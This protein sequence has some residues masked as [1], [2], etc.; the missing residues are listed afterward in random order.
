M[1]SLRLVSGLL[2]GLMVLAVAGWAW[3][4]EVRQV[5]AEGVAA[6]QSGAAVARDQAVE[7]ALRR[8]VEQAVGVLVMAET[9]VRNRELLADKIYTQAKGYVQ[10]YK[11]VSER[12]D[13]GLYRVAIL[14]DVSLE[15]LRN[16]L[17]AIRL[18]IQR[19]GKPRVLFLV[20]EE[21]THSYGPGV[22]AYSWSGASVTENVLQRR[23]RDQGFPV[24]EARSAGLD[25]A[26]ARSA[27]N[28]DV[29]A[30]QRVSQM[31]Q[32]EVVV[33]GNARAQGGSPIAGSSLRAVL[34]DMT[35]RAVRADTGELLA[36]ARAS[37]SAPHVEV[38]AGA[39]EAF[40]KGGDEMASQ[41]IARVLDQWAKETSGS[42]SIQLLLS[43]VRSFDQLQSVLAHLRDKVRG[44]S[45]VYR[46]SFDQARGQALIDVDFR[47]DAQGLADS[48]H[49]TAIGRSRLSIV[50]AT[51]NRLELQLAP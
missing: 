30:L 29:R 5:Q 47:G 3:A 10:G 19:A 12:Q 13:G 25:A 6:I 38:S 34:A 28:G 35:A 41:L 7:D 43:G 51:P 8:A 36:T 17:A 1:S 24:V 9:V 2:L 11:I 37:S 48:L 22:W 26:T 32:A 40:E 42:R 20:E 45:Q 16:D 39:H 33:V 44:V 46:R 4:Q 21:I 50:S 15:P 27:H 49:G 14:A 23:F 31:T 18:L